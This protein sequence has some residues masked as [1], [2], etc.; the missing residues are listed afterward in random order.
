M[1]VKSLWNILAPASRA[2]RL[3]SLQGKILA[4][5]ASIWLYQLLKAMRD[6]NGDALD[7]GALLGFFRRIC[8]LLFWG[9]KPVF[10]FDGEAPPLKQATMAERRRRKEGKSHDVAQTARELLSTQLRLAA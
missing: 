9:I 2:V 6:D 3:E 7:G 8:K 5:D 1:G 10:V 4:I